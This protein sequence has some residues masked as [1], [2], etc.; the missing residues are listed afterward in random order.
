MY[1]MLKILPRRLIF[2]QKIRIDDKK[3]KFCLNVVFFAQIFRYEATEK[4]DRFDKYDLH[5]QF[6]TN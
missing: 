5:L 4:S 3:E 1:D 6:Q 2:L